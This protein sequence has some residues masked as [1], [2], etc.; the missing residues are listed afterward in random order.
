MVVTTPNREFNQFFN[1]AP[2]ELR[3]ADH[4]FEYSAAQFRQWID[5]H[6]PA[7]GSGY[8]VEVGG[9]KYPNPQRIVGQY[10]HKLE[11]FKEVSA[12]HVAV[13]RRKRSQTAAKEAALESSG[14]M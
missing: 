14:I 13:F 9:I 6:A 11:E 2:T 7:A 8:D 3:D 5:K 1:L 4:K 12:T 10:K